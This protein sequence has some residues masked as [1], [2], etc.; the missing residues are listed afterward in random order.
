M[1]K[2][3]QLEGILIKIVKK[4]INIFAKF[5]VKDIRK[6]EFPDQLKTAYIIPAFKNGGKHDTSNYRPLS[7]LPILS[8]VYEKCLYKQMENYMENILSNSQCDFRKG[9]KAQQCLIGMIEKAKRI[10]NNGGHLSVLLTDL[11]KMFD[12]LPHDL[13]IAKLDA[14]GFENDALYLIFNYFNNRKQRVKTNSFFSSFQNIIS[15]VPQSSLLGPL[16]FNIFLLKLQATQRTTHHTQREIVLKNF[17][18]SRKGL[19]HSV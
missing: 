12:C 10:M 19:K 1:S 9:F 4:N 16:L 7:I 15:G 5:L 11:S 2:T 14:Y 17:A 6:G 8:K 18:K 13:L 3:T